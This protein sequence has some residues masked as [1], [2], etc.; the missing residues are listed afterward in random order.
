[1]PQDELDSRRSQVRIAAAAVERLKAEAAGA[2]E[3]LR[4]HTILAPFAGV[5]AQKA[6]E[7]GE[8]VSP[9]TTLVEL[10]AIDDLRVDIPVPQK[11]Y[12]QLRAETPIALQ[13]DALPGQSFEA[14]RIAMVPISDPT[15]RTFMLRV[16]PVG[17][18]IPLMPGMSAQASLN[19][20][21]GEQGIVISRDA[22]IR[23]PDGRTTVWVVEGTKDETTIAER[24]V[25]LGRA[26]DGFIQ[27]RHGLEAGERVVETGNEALRSGQQVSLVDGSS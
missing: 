15:V 27:V 6:T 11:Y 24:H 18:A 5:V 3:N 17:G 9:G 20:A 7:A 16:Q 2:R 1:M 22:V 13:F 4:R 23:Y 12:P 25:Q 19:L 26:F 14:R 21:T 10:V 8:W